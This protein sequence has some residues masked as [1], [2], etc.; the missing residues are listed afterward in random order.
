L[1]I[2]W[3]FLQQNIYK[4]LDMSSH[5]I[6]IAINKKLN[7]N[8]LFNNHDFFICGVG[9]YKNYFLERKDRKGIHVVSILVE[10]YDGFIQPHLSY[11]DHLDG[12]KDIVAARFKFESSFFVIHYSNREETFEYFLDNFIEYFCETYKDE[13]C[14]FMEDTSNTIYEINDFYLKR[15]EHT[16]FWTNPLATFVVIKKKKWWQ[17]WN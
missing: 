12:F 1:I 6:S 4:F 9:D 13:D 5:F 14:I 11:E 3:I 17:F 2:L 15:K 10:D 7:V 16:H 8:Q